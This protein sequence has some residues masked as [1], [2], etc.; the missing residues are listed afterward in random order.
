M[1]TFKCM[2]ISIGMKFLL[3]NELSLVGAEIPF[4][5]HLLLLLMIMAGCGCRASYVDCQL[6]LYTANRPLVSHLSEKFES[7]M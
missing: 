5:G 4:L 2:H 1:E 6:I 3:L 7:A